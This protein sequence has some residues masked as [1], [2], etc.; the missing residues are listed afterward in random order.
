MVLAPLV[1]VHLITIIFVSGENLSA[2]EI[3][4]RTQG[5]YIWGFFYGLFV[6]A[7]AVHGA[8][9]LRVIVQEVFG[10]KSAYLDALAFSLGLL[11]LILGFRAI[12]ILI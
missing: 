1:I 4:A 10:L 5:N 6:V 8:I 7:A 9:G 2:N 11:V 12:A 3:L